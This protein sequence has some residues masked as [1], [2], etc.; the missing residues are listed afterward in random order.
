M[1]LST[2]QRMF[3]L[4]TPLGEDALLIHE[5]E[6]SEALSR[7][8]EFKFKLISD[9]ADIRPDELI[10]KRATLRVETFDGE[11]FWT[12]II[13]RFIRTGNMRAPEGAEGEVFCYECDLVPWLWH[14]LQHEDRKSV[15]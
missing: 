7:P 6:G 13:S 15:V 4:N 14:M 2:E 5:M 8:Y 10:G 3:V 11:R 9:Q 1:P 12:G